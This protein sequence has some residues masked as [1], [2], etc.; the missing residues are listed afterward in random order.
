VLIPLLTVEARLKRALRYHLKQLG[1]GRTPEGGLAPPD[2]SKD[3]YRQL[4]GAQL[5][6]RLNTERRFI[7]QAWAQLRGHFAHGA[8]IDP[9]YIDPRLEMIH[10]G[11]WQSDLFR[12][13]AL[14]WSVPVSQGYGRRLRFLVW[15]NNN[16]KLLGL[17][18]LADPVFNLA[19]RDQYIGWSADDRRKRLVHVLDAYVLGALPPYN[20]LLGGKLVAALVGTREIRDTFAQKYSGARGLISG[21]VKPAALALVTTSSALGRSSVY[22]RLRLANYR[23]FRSVGYTSGWGHFHIPDRLFSMMREYLN[24][25]GHPYADNHRFGD[26]PNWKLR[27]VRECL[28]LLDLNTDWLR[29]GIAR[30]VFI[31]ELAAN[32]RSFLAGRSKRLGYGGLPTISDVTAA[33]RA[34]WLEPRAARR[35]E[36]GEWQLDSFAEVLGVSSAATRVMSARS[37]AVVD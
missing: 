32:A 27:A 20:M 3:G 35:P 12:L 1:F 6:D 11:T 17:I 10:G 4:H 37:R 26:G 7:R 2:S 33:A 19:V 9:P 21:E 5:R 29:H 8:E 30:E 18:A 34:R 31:C 15:D 16:D 28:R 25:L 23:L 13:A 14:T 22:N 36:F 24:V